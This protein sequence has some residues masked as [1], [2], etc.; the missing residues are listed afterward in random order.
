VGEARTT[1]DGEDVGRPGA[2]VL[3]V[4]DLAVAYGRA[5]R[6]LAG[7][8]LSVASGATVAVLG[9]NGAG[10]TTLLRAIT[11]LLGHHRG[12]ITSGSVRLDGEDVAGRAAPELVRRG[13]SQVMEGRRIFAPL[14]VEENLRV[15]ARVL[16]R[17]G[18]VE[19]ERL[20]DLFPV[21]ADKRR[22][23]AGSLSGGEQQQLAIAR[24]LVQ[25][26]RLLVLDEPTLGLSPIMVAQVR[27]LLRSLRGDGTSV[28][29]VE[30]RVAVAYAVADHVHLLAGG[31]IVQHGTPQ[32]LADRSDVIDTYLGAP[33]HG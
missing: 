7:V 6:A 21:L 31:R 5:G 16:G 22:D 27:E 20:L 11:G 10:K 18:R 8:S 3:V 29:L 25:S 24:A 9:A 1:D 4:E 12:Q 32:Q 19:V 23:R 30:Q 17:R 15:G 14:S 28:L 26:P 13:I 33:V 2:P